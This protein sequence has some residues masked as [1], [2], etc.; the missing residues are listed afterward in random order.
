MKKFRDMTD[1]EKLEIINAMINGDPVEGRHHEHEVV[2]LSLCLGVNFDTFYRIPK[3]PISIDWDVLK[4]EYICAA[5]DRYDHAF[6]YMEK[7][8]K[9]A[10]GWYSPMCVAYLNAIK[11]YDP[12][13]IEWDESLIWRPGYEPKGDQNG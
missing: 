13:T 11:S 8:E 2:S 4:D 5:R 10:V 12:G 9:T 6:G 3:R 7:P 1:S